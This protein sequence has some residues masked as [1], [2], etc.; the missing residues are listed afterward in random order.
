MEFIWLVKLIGYPLFIYTLTCIVSGK[1]LVKWAGDYKLR[2]V[3]KDEEPGTYLFVVIIYLVFS[4]F[5]I[6]VIEDF[7]LDLGNNFPRRVD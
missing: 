7:I 6:F 2:V 5:L 3:E 1:I 4:Y